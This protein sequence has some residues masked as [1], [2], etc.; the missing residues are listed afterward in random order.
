VWPW[1][2]GGEGDPGDRVKGGAVSWGEEFGVEDS[3]SAA[4]IY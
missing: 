4:G 3:T 2:T 1:F